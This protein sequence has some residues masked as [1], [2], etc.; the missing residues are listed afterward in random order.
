[1]KKTLKS[2]LLI[3]FL[4]TI[5]FALT[6]CGGSKLV[7]TKE[8][9]DSFLGKYEEKLE[10]KFKNKKADEMKQTLTFDNEDDAKKVYDAYNSGMI[11]GAEVEQ[12]GKKVIITMDVEKFIGE[13]DDDESLS[14]DSIKKELE[15][16]G[17]K[18]K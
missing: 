14:K 13:G 7:A 4:A 5:L 16:D 15:E 17:Y 18:V 8:N 11:D 12:K 2:A 10:I 9:D 6:G 3:M 1:M